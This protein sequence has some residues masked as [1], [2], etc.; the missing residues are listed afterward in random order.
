MVKVQGG[1]LI[2]SARPARVAAAR[3]AARRPSPDGDRT[4]GSCTST[5]IHAGAESDSFARSSA[6][7][8]PLVA[9]A[10]FLPIAEQLLQL[11]LTFE[12]RDASAGATV[13]HGTP[14]GS[15]RT[16]ARGGPR[17]TERRPERRDG[18]ISVSAPWWWSY[19]RLAKKKR[20][21]EPGPPCLGH[22]RRGST[23]FGR[24]GALLGCVCKRPRALR[25]LME[26]KKGPAKWVSKVPRI[27]RIAQRVPLPAF[28]RSRPSSVGACSRVCSRP[29]SS[30]QKGTKTAGGSSAHCQ[31]KWPFRAQMV[32]W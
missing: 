17:T 30:P 31:V 29:R 19:A 10:R 3:R 11:S 20:G 6:P 28:R 13:L 25:N 15:A 32:G 18:P 23:G 12:S 2:R 22:N 27:I 1:R 9:L 5:P 4:F 7:A 16:E 26:G 14:L 21:R 24:L 8:A